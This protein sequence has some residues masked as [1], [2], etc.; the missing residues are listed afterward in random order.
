MSYTTADYCSNKYTKC[1]NVFKDHHCAVSHVIFHS[2][3]YTDCVN[4]NTGP[5]YAV[6]H[7]IIIIICAQLGE[8]SANTA[9]LSQLKSK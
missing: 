8:V 1:V 4:A 7:I 5:H 3:M 9:Q 6:S 2:N